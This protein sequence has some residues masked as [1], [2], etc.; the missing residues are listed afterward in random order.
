MYSYI[1]IDQ[2]IYYVHIIINLKVGCKWIFPGS[3]RHSSCRNSS[4]L[5]AAREILENELESIRQAGTF[6]KER[7]ITSK[8]AVSVQVQGQ[9][10]PLLNFCANNYLGLSVTYSTLCKVDEL[11]TILL[12]FVLESSRSDSSRCECTGEIRCWSVVCAIYL[13]HSRP[14]QGSFFKKKVIC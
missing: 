9:L 13:R 14:S 10:K 2:L 11:E 1:R 3:T 8:Q 5:V 6:K 4:A 7:V 12:P